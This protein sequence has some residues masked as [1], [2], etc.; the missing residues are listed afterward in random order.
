M[1]RVAIVGCSDYSESILKDALINSFNFFGGIENFVGAG[2]R[3][4]LKPNL[5]AASKGDSATTDARFIE[6]VIK[7]V[8]ERN[9][10]PFVGDS[11]A[12]GSA[13]GVAKSVGLM[14][15]LERQQVNIVEFKKNLH[16]T[17][18]IF[19]SKS[20][21]DF[22]R[23]INLPKLKAHS[24]VRFTGATKNLF[25]FTKGKIK[26]WRH[27]IVK[28]DLEKFCL[29]LLRINEFVKPAFTLVD[30]VD[31]MEE[32]G[33]RGGPIRRFGCLFA[34][35]NCISIDRVM[36]L[37]LGIDQKDMPLLCAAKKYGFSGGDLDQIEIKGEAI[38]AVKLTD[39][40]FP[41][42]LT[43]ISF[44]LKGVIRSLFRHLYMLCVEKRQ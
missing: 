16:L 18:D 10:I 14:E 21:K 9:A 33:P 20:V 34:G 11:P 38:D 42:T 40:A 44:T 3:V 2:D 26:A 6:A 36:G 25:G 12:F 22:D 24:Q 5:I 7:L 23:I 15:A 13:K 17:K 43:D 32:K 1:E 37:C 19:I 8:K 31:I 30:A 35:I 4:L 28:N 39:F 29:M 41:Q 27:F